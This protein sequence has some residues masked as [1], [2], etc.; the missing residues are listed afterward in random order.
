MI[1]AGRDSE[2]A[3]EALC[4]AIAREVMGWEIARIE[5]A[6]SG[7]APVW[8]DGAGHPL[9]TRYSWQPD[10]RDAQALEVV[11]RMLELGFRF[12]LGAEQGRTFAVFETGSTESRSE[13][14]DRRIAILRAALRAVS[15]RETT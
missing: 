13:H 3:R 9:L 4:D 12:A 10:R 8:H 14:R 7:T 5:W 6:Y 1:D 2:E 11:D 15:G